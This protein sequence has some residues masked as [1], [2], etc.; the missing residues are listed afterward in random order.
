MGSPIGNFFILLV[1]LCYSSREVVLAQHRLK[2]EIGVN[3]IVCHI[4]LPNITNLHPAMLLP[5]NE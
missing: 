3:S 2:G 1:Y 4:V 5:I